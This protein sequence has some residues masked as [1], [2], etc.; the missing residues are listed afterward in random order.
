M[1]RLTHPDNGFHYCSDDEAIQ[2][3]K[4]GW[5]VLTDAEWLKMLE[6]KRSGNA[7]AETEVTTLE[8]PT[9]PT[10]GRPKKA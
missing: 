8:V 10:L 7:P 4:D 5:R 3:I 2:M 6:K 9:R 1:P